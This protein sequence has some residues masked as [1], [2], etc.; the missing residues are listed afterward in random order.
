MNSLKFGSVV[1]MNFHFGKIYIANC[2][3][4][5]LGPLWGRECK[6]FLGWFRKGTREWDADHRDS[7][8]LGLLAALICICTVWFTLFPAAFAVNNSNSDCNPIAIYLSQKVQLYHISNLLSFSKLW[9]CENYIRI[10][11]NWA[12][13]WKLAFFFFC[14]IIFPW[15]IKFTLVI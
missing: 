7:I 8:T 9:T 4:L 6:N 13:L 2:C 11:Q 5:E 15:W 1:A 14:H 10:Y 3:F 12:C